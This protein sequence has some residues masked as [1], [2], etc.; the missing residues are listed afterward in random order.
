MKQTTGIH[1]AE[2]HFSS[3]PPAFPSYLLH[4]MFQ[5]IYFFFNYFTCED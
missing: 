3:D 5:L 2:Q 4:I 1:W